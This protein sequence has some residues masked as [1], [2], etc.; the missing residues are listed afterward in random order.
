MRAGS[1][2][3]AFVLT[4]PG[5]ASWDGKWSGRDRLW[6]VVRSC[7]AASAEKILAKSSYGYSFGDGWCARVDVRAVD[8]TEAARINKKSAGFAGYDWMVDE[9]ENDQ[10]ITGAA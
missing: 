8:T 1:V 2:R 6:A 5:C 3:I 9:I 4:M 10:R 7:A